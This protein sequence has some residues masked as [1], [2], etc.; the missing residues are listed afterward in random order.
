MDYVGEY[1]FARNA[2]FKRGPFGS[3]LK[4]SIFVSEGYKI[5]EQYCPINDDCSYARYFVTPEKFAELEAFSV[6]A[7]DFLISCSGVTLGRITQVPKD[8]DEGIIN[9]ALLRVRL[10]AE[11]M[12]DQ[13]FKWLFRSP[14]F[15]KHIFD[16]S[17]GSAIP[18]VKGVKELKAIPI[19]LPPISEQI[20]INDILI[21][22]LASV[23]RLAS[24]LK[25]ATLSIEQLDQS[26]LK[27]AFQGK[28]VPQDPNDEPASILLASIQATRK[29]TAASKKKKSKKKTT[30]TKK[31][32]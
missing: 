17:T 3:A 22:A 32:K 27:K 21:N 10:N 5:Y 23:D 18:N 6:R 11:A 29:A 8:F 15:Q 16:N 9:Q 28:L 7:N 24:P 26:I 13:Y 14:F 25:T 12:E 19:P 30:R 1:S 2:S 4:K 31:A 20:E